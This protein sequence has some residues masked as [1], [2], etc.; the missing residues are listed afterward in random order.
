[1]KRA[2]KVLGL[3]VVVGLVVAVTTIGYL[4]VTLCTGHPH[5]MC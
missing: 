4:Y 3:V 1:M 2:L 5:G